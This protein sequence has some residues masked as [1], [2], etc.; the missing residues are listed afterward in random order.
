V[1]AM[2]MVFLGG[3]VLRESPFTAI[4]MLWVNLIMDTFASLALATEPPSA[5]LLKRK[6]YTRTE[7]LVTPVM[8]RNILGQALY[9]IIV[10]IVLLFK[11]ASIFGVP[12][13]INNEEWTE[14]NG[15]HYTIVFNTFVFMQVVNFVNARKL[16]TSEVNVFEGFFNNPMFLAIEITIFV[17]QILFVELGGKAIRTAPLS[18]GQYLACFL[19]GAFSLV[20]GVIIKKIPTSYFNNI[21]I[22]KEEELTRED[23]ESTT[24]GHFR[25]ASTLSKYKP[26]A[27]LQH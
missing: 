13:G 17:M 14:E 2:F 18:A 24:Q 21:T 4:Q 5:D 20:I 3:V 16:K 10:L 23:L 6:P 19:I 9:Q 8:W 11:G 22:L 27:S 7:S 25:K 12:S 15:A 26:Q 1:V